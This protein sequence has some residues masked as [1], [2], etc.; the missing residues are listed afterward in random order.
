M[1]TGQAGTDPNQ[2]QYRHWGNKGRPKSPPSS[3][4]S[5]DNH[6]HVTHFHTHP[7]TSTHTPLS[8]PSDRPLSTPP[9]N[10]MPP[11]AGPISL[12]PPT[13]ASHLMP[14]QGLVPSQVLGRSF[15]TKRPPPKPPPGGDSNPTN[16]S[17][18]HP[19]HSTDTQG[20]PIHPVRPPPE[21][22][23]HEGQQALH[24]D[25]S[26]GHGLF[27]SLSHGFSSR[28]PLSL[29]PGAAVGTSAGTRFQD[30]GSMERTHSVP[31][32]VQ[33]PLSTR[34]SRD[35]TSP[36]P[37]L[38]S[39]D[40]RASCPSPIQR[41]RGQGLG[42]P[43]AGM[44]G[45]LSGPAMGPSPGSERLT[46]NTVHGNRSGHPFPGNLGMTDHLPTGSPSA[47][48]SP[49]QSLSSPATGT[50]RTSQPGHAL[51]AFQRTFPDQDCDLDQGSFSS[52]GPPRTPFLPGSLSDSEEANPLALPEEQ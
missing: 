15:H 16:S 18:A 35:C 44:S 34:G 9:G 51:R 11:G 31:S 3:T 47:P 10:M 48:P 30:N 36:P 50:F 37:P 33:H 38:L 29:N 4:L 24:Q 1:P 20:A 28:T 52:K 41:V 23:P 22:P 13:I 26:Q 43:L 46:H 7:L 42:S 6:L 8:G 39:R 12:G 21:P 49:T 40:T 19:P 14:S 2:A 17:S 32:P 45:P 25:H 27:P 5:S